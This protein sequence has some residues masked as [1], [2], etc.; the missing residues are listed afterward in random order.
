LKLC[1]AAVIVVCYL[2]WVFV[3]RHLAA[4]RWMETRQPPESADDVAEA[5]A[6]GRAFQRTYGGTDV[7]ILQF[8]AR[9]GELIEGRSTVLCYGVL[10]ARSVEI[11]PPVEGVSP[12]LNR[13]VEVAPRA[14]T[15]YTLTAQGKDGRR[16]SE[17]FV[18]NVKPDVASYPRI[19]SF[20]V[21]QH[22][23]EGGRAVFLLSFSDVNG[24]E[25]AIDP[26]VFPTLHGAPNGQFWVAPAATTTYTLTVTGT[27]GRKARQQLT[28]E[29]P[30]K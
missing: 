21:A 3:A 24:E 15:R 2:G 9:D 23:V 18:L 13:C 29:V 16:V 4:R 17:S 28:V 6:R 25:I 20:R 5:N 10:N 12:A 26:A 22:R 30:S 14:D 7:R 27:R 8:Y 11:A 19:T 1:A